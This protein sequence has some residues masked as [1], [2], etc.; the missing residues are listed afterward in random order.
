MSPSSIGYQP[1]CSDNRD[2]VTGGLTVH[3]FVVFTGF[4][5]ASKKL[6]EYGTGIDGVLC[7]RIMIKMPFSSVNVLR[8]ICS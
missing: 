8:S 5:G 7:H 1:R 3:S 6:Y 4:K 2:L